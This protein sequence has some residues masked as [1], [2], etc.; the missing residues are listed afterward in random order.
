[1]A[2][3]NGRKECV[4][5]LL[6]ECSQ[7]VNIYAR[8]YKGRTPMSACAHIR[9]FDAVW[10]MMMIKVDGD[11]TEEEESKPAR[12]LPGLFPNMWTCALCSL[13]NS[14]SVEECTVCCAPRDPTQ[15]KGIVE[16]LLEGQEIGY[17]ESK[18]RT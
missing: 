3:A 11:G 7:K 12:A 14:Q 8:D 10:R 13:L 5:V 18:S 6:F 4:S 1:M 9:G 17:R 2:A 15:Q 16:V